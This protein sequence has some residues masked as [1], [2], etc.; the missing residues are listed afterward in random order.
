M[1]TFRYNLNPILIKT[2]DKCDIDIK[3]DDRYAKRMSTISLFD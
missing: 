3:S 2:K 1:E